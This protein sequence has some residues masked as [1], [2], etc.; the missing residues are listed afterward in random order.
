VVQL[1]LYLF[2]V[3]SALTSGYIA[4]IV[5]LDEHGLAIPYIRLL[6]PSHFVIFPDFGLQVGFL[7]ETKYADIAGIMFVPVLL[8]SP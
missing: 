8:T 3:R 5:T 4:D 2:F 6:L 1:R 7:T